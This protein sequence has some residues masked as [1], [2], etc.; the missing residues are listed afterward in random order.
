MLKIKLI[1]LFLFLFI[2]TGTAFGQGT[3]V[4]PLNST[5]VDTGCASFSACTYTDLNVPPGQHFYFVIAMN[6]AGY[7]GPSN[8]FYCTVPAGSHNVVL[9][10]N[11]SNSDPT[12]GYFLWRG[13]PPTNINAIG[14]F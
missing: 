4:P 10:W 14:T 3:S 13:A 6:A 5:A 9:N 11:P 12:V 8:A 1:A 7:S 2:C